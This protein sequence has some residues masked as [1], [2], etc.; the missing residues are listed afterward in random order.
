MFSSFTG[1]VHSGGTESMEAASMAITRSRQTTT[2]TFLSLPR[3]LRQRICLDI[4]NDTLATI[5][6]SGWLPYV[7]KA[8]LL[9]T[10]IFFVN[11]SFRAH[12]T[13]DSFQETLPELAEDVEW[14][15]N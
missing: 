4:V 8:K 3:E 9:S 6:D 12:L 11:L 5:Y 2:T 7:L 13:I 1:H 14:I 10:R 15:E